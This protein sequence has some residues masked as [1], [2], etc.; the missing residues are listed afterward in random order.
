MLYYFN[1]TNGRETIPDHQGVE[2]LCLNAALIQA[3]QTIEELR[4]EELSS[5][6]VWKGWWLEIVDGAGLLVEILPLDESLG[7]ATRRC[8][9]PRP[10][11]S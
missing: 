8:E 3:L 1:L 6:Y 2:V 7:R 9:R 11:D 5:S 10:Q 4:E